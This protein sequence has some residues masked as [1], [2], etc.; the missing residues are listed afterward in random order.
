M[1]IISHRST[2]K[3][4]NL[5]HLPPLL[6]R[7]YENRGITQSSEL[8][9]DLSALLPYHGL[10]Q[11][12][13]AVQRLHLALVKQESIVIVGDFDADGATSCALAITA[14]QSFGATQ[15][16][17]LVPNRFDYGYG[18]TPEIVALAIKRLQ[19]TLI[20]TVDNGVAN[21]A[22]V[23]AA[24][25]AGIDVIITDHHLPA[26]T[27]PEPAI[28][29]NPNKANCHFA[30][31]N[32]A[33]VGVIFYV[34]LA[35]RAHLRDVGWFATHHLALPNM[36]HLLDLVALGTIA[37]VVP[38]D[39]NNRILVYQGLQ[40]IRHG[41]ARPGIQ[42][43]L[44]VAKRSAARLVASDLAFGVAPRLNAA[45]RLEDMSIGIACLLSEH[46]DLAYD[47]ALQLDELNQ[48]RKCIEQDMQEQARHALGQCE[49]KASPQLA[50]GL[51][52]YHDS[53]HQGVVGILAS[54]IKEQYHRPTIAFAKVSATELK[55]SARSIAGLHIRDVLSN[56]AAQYPQLIIKFGG[57]AMAAGLSL[58]IENYDKFSAIFAA[59]VAK[60]LTPA[61]LQ[62]SLLTDGELATTQFSLAVA[63]QLREAGPWGQAFPEPSFDGTFSVLEQRIVGT[64][65]L[66]LY[67]RPSHS[68]LSID[69]IAFNVDLTQ[70]PNHR[71]NTIHAV[72]R[73][74]V[75]EYQGL[76]R[77]QLL[78]EHLES[79]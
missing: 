58:A 12:G 22:G 53:W 29:V 36:A 13:Q 41:L 75:N 19:P 15:L 57:H 32:L 14:L 33:G 45:G 79:K 24:A 35:L 74:D 65:H 68:D 63:Q 70:W 23:N 27:L 55:G 2:V 48:K 73:L 3:D 39:H 78:I 7:I 52:L 44:Q 20:I 51:T 21:H 30:S 4:S 49:F 28:I 61:D 50:P 38:L 56:I 26:E 31:K 5:A 76:Q 16:S 8:V 25:A 43:L 17:Y 46:Y 34:M 1:P 10:D 9:T 71:C 60:H 59:E 64:R 69:A 67:L 37:D 72:Y 77:L 62:V 6:Q 66:K 54:R 47:I 42:A 11:I 40:R 18:L